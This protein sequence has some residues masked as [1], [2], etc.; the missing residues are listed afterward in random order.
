MSETYIS[1]YRKWRSQSLDEIIGQ[2]F[3][4]QTLK[5]SL[6]NQKIA[7][8]YLFCG[9]RG[10]GKT[11]IARIFAKSVNCQENGISP[12]PCQKC[13]SCRG[14][15]DGTS[16]DVFEIDAASNRGVDD[17]RQLRD[18]VKFT[19]VKS[20]FKVYI[21]DEVHMLTG[22]AFNALLKT[23]EEPPP[24]VIFILATTE[25]HKIPVT[26]LSRCMRFDLKRISTDSQVKLL[27]Q[28]ADSEK[29]DITD[30]ALR[31]LAVQSNGSLR[32]SES[33]LDQIASF[34]DGKIDLEE[35]NSLLGIM[36]ESFLNDLLG[37]V[38]KGDRES[39]IAFVRQAYREGKDPGQMAN[40]LLTR[41]HIDIL[42]SLGVSSKELVDDFAVNPEY[43][44]QESKNIGFERLRQMELGLRD[45]VSHMKY[46][47]S[48]ILH[49]EMAVLG[50]FDQPALRVAT[51]ESPAKPAKAEKK[52]TNSQ[53]KPTPKKENSPTTESPEETP[54]EPRPQPPKPE[55][56]EP[57]A[58]LDKIKWHA[59]KSDILLLAFFTK[60]TEAV[61][62]GDAL[63]L[64]MAS[65]AEFERNRLIEPENN[66]RLKNLAAKAAGKPLQVKIELAK[67]TDIKQDKD[68]QDA[69]K[70]FGGQ[71]EE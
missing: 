18:K 15:T 8:A 41:V 24:H 38:A 53:P 33:M 61:V 27:R 16:L 51:L 5:N 28:I 71:I 35:I 49:L 52:I 21:I 45:A 50:L 13:D 67:T 47:F 29:I 43:V 31:K 36:G 56:P 37:F 22:E 10:V 32:D 48:P 39:A 42:S 70:L 3:A 55:E 68:I 34:A 63:L 59:R 12:E 65:D 9:P 6:K 4:V 20:R 62:E 44:E 11:S 23:L 14:I 26:I 66:N 25:S 69:V 19:P 1:L 2:D 30:D 60:I 58:L 17:I 7:H 40:D 54:Q 57:E 64:K 46:S